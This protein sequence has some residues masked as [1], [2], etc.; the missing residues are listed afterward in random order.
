MARASVE[1]LYAEEAGGKTHYFQE[2]AASS[3]NDW[4]AGDLVKLDSNGEL[5]IATAGAILGIACKAASGTASTEIPVIVL[6]ST[7]TC[8][9]KHTTSATNENM[10]GDV[11][12]FTFTAG[13]HTLA[14]GGT[15]DVAILDNHPDDAWGTSGGKMLVR[16]LDAGLQM[17]GGHR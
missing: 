10:A 12:D 2:A 9:A 14:T 8:V 5:V 7:M 15:T 13:A 3:A 4:Y 1:L 17:G 6:D 16:F 11:H